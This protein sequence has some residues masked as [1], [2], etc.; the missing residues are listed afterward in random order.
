MTGR[1]FDSSPRTQNLKR[2]E[3]EV[4]RRLLVVF[5]LSASLLVGTCFAWDAE[6][7]VGNDYVDA[8][9]SSVVSSDS[10]ASTSDPQ[11]QI[12]EYNALES[13]WGQQMSDNFDLLEVP[14]F[15]ASFP[16]ALF[17]ACALL[18]GIFQDIWAAFGDYQIFFVFPLY[19][20]ICLFL[21]GR[22]SRFLSSSRGGEEK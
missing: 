12:D 3:V 15:Y 11:S 17:S 21:V 6:S 16:V 13:D 20:A 22:V 19:L 8:P 7:F 1:W 14:D 2:G 9:S 10:S 4:I 5:S 18:S